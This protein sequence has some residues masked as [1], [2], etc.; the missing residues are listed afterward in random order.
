MEKKIKAS[1]GDLACIIMEAVMGNCASIM[2][3]KGYL[4]FVRKLCDQY[5]IVLVFDEVKTGFRIAKGGVQEYFNVKADLVTYAKA[6]GNGFPVAAIGGKKDI[7]KGLLHADIVQGGTYTGNAVATAAACATLDEI[8]KGALEKVNAHGEKLKAGIGKILQERGS[9][10]FVQGPA[11]MVKRVVSGV[12]L[13][14][15]NPR[16]NIDH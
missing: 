11:A 15:L 7:M 4:E 12:S 14:L 6:L 9:P 2:P 5:G 10:G 3:K 13:A 1:W 16:G 8:D